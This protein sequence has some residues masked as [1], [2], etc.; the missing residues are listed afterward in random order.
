[1]FVYQH[2]TTRAVEPTVRPG[3]GRRLGTTVAVTV[4]ADSKVD[5]YKPVRRVGVGGG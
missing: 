5:V 4:S 3:P 1:M 2:G